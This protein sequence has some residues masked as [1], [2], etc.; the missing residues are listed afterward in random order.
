M[1][2]NQAMNF[3]HWQTEYC[4]ASADE[5]K[6][7][8]N[9]LSYIFFSGEFKPAI[10]NDSLLGY[11]VK[12]QYDAVAKDVLMRIP[13]RAYGKFDLGIPEK[14]IIKNGW[15]EAY[16]PKHFYIGNSSPIREFEDGDIPFNQD[17]IEGLKEI[18]LYYIDLLENSDFFKEI[19]TSVVYKEFKK[20]Q[21]L[22]LYRLLNQ[23][24]YQL[25]Q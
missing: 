6:H 22:I 3:Y 10:A 19:V 13:D 4:F 17:W 23:C 1:K 5:K 24:N 25:N 18:C 21:L 16:Y 7:R 20:S 12:P 9:M 14:Q 8:I 15:N 11:F 2:L